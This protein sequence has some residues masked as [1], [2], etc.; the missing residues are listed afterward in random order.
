MYLSCSSIPH[1]SP[2]SSGITLRAFYAYCLNG[3]KERTPEI[4]YLFIFIDIVRKKK[5]KKKH[6]VKVRV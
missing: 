6:G 1:P 3:K 5:A 4:Y 2:S